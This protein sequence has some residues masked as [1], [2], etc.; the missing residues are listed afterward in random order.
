[1]NKLDARNDEKNNDYCRLNCITQ[2]RNMC[3]I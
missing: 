3:F 1:M 2:R